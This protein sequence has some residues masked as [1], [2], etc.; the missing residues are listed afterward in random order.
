MSAAV[1][2]IG[3]RNKLLGHRNFFFL[4]MPLH[5]KHQRHGY[6]MSPA[7]YQINRSIQHSRRQIFSHSDDIITQEASI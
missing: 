7:V 6:D 2:Q 4:M 1:F 5:N 3:R